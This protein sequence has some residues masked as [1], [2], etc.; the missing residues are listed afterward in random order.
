VLTD[1]ASVR[2]I[3]LHRRYLRISVLLAVATP[4]LCFAAFT[5]HWQVGDWWL[6]R[7][8]PISGKVGWRIMFEYRRYDVIRIDSVDSH[9]CYVLQMEYR[10]HPSDSGNL[11]E[12]YYVRTDKWIVVRQ[13]GFQRTNRG[14]ERMLHWDFPRGQLETNECGLCLPHFPLEE[15]PAS[16]S[17]KL[18]PQGDGTTHYVHERSATADS[19]VVTVCLDA[20]DTP[21][22]PVL[23]P[24]GGVVYSYRIESDPSAA[25][26]RRA[27]SSQLWCKS[28]PWGSS[29]DTINDFRCP[30]T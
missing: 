20:G 5:P 21:A 27:Y 17:L 18:P 13:L 15:R 8:N 12:E 10:Q 6:T 29:G 14:F 2:V 22:E 24:A 4:A 19:A 3:R 16:R 9:P 23:R 11:R 26:R 7:S 25:I 28:Q 1:T 30:R